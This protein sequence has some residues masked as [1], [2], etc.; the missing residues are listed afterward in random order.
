VSSRGVVEK[1]NDTFVRTFGL[2]AAAVQGQVVADLGIDVI[3]AS[4]LSP[5]TRFAGGS[6]RSTPR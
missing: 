2:S 4:V 5:S 3:D 6:S 1:A